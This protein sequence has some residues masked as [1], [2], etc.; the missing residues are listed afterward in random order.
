MPTL[1]RHKRKIKPSDKVHVCTFHISTDYYLWKHT[2]KFTVVIIACSLFLKTTIS[3]CWLKLFV[4][5]QNDHYQFFQQQPH[6]PTSW[7]W[8]C[9][10]LHHSAQSQTNSPSILKGFRFFNVISIHVILGLS[11]PHF[12]LLSIYSHQN[13]IG[14]YVSMWMSN[15]F[16]FNKLFKKK[17]T[18]L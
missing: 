6:S 15:L 12:P 16:V 10:H 2:K 8:L 13:L 11:L 3:F 4:C 9:D 17:W 5:G 1:E 14:G 18:S 7:H